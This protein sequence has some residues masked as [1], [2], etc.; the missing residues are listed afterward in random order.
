MTSMKLSVYWCGRVKQKHRATNVIDFVHKHVSEIIDNV[1]S[2]VLHSYLPR[3]K[4][5]LLV[6]W[7]IGFLWV[8]LC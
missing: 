7:I 2:Q 3:Q 6:F 1:F 5:L 8:K 4:Q